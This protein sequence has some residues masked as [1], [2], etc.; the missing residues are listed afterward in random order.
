M[1]GPHVNRRNADD[2]FLA[3]AT[4]TLRKHK[5]SDLQPDSQKRKIQKKADEIVE[6]AQK[7][8]KK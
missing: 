5:S 2:V 1:P 8:G 4:E 3:T 7:K 6:K